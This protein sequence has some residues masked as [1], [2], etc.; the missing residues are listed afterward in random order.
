MNKELLIK[1]NNLVLITGIMIICI[2]IGAIYQAQQ[3]VKS[4]NQSLYN[5]SVSGGIL[6]DGNSYYYIGRYNNQ[7]NFSADELLNRTQ[8]EAL[9][10]DMK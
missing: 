10:G 3:D 6:T 2:G 1:I 8:C 7:L 9:Y 5:I 4:L